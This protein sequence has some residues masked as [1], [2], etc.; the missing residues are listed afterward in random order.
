MANFGIFG[1]EVHHWERQCVDDQ[2]KPVVV[3]KIF[4]SW[5]SAEGN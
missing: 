4:R 1:G 3:P 2:L 5:Q